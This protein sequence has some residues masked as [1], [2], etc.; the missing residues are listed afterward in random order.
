MNS[1]NIKKY[2]KASWLIVCA[3]D[4]RIRQKPWQSLLLR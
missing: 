3:Q 1:L 2:L 4:Q